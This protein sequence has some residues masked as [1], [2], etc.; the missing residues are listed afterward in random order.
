MKLMTSWSPLVTTLLDRGGERQIS[1]APLR[2]L[3]HFLLLPFYS[4]VHSLDFSFH[5]RSQSSKS[6]ILH[7]GEVESCV[8]SSKHAGG[9]IVSASGCVGGV[10][11]TKPNPSSVLRS[12]YLGCPLSPLPLPHSTIVLVL[13]SPPCDAIVGTGFRR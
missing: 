5:G 7:V 2:I 12:S 11:S 4:M 3:L 8:F 9:D 6:S 13:L 1:W 10:K